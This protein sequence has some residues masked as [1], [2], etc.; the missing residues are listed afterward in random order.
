MPLLK[1]PEPQTAM[2][3]FFIRIEEPLALNMERYAEFL[4]TD[5]APPGATLRLSEVV[6]IFGYKPDS[7]I[8]TSDLFSI[9]WRMNRAC[10]RWFSRRNRYPE[11]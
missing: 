5:R 7:T 6:E 10:R 9:G 11:Q 1:P 3:K 8:M 2:R 4:G